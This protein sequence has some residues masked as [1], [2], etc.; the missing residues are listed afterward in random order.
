MAIGIM[1]KDKEK[2]GEVTRNNNFVQLNLAAKKTNIAIVV[3]LQTE[4]L[5][6]GSRD[7]DIGFHLNEAN[8]PLTSQYQSVK[9][10]AMIVVLAINPT[11]RGGW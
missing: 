9:D 5:T 2:S 11:C 1:N 6:N 10:G 8:Y 7:F 4:N 3:N